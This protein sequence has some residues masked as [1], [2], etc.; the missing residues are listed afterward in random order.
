MERA[1]GSFNNLPIFS[2]WENGKAHCQGEEFYI[3]ATSISPVPVGGMEVFPFMKK[4]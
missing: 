2:S 1:S 4:H 3:R